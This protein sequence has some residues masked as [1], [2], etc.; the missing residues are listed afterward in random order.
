MHSDWSY[1]FQ[2]RMIT[3]MT[4]TMTM[5]IIMIM[6]MHAFIYECMYVFVCTSS[7]SCMCMYD[8][9]IIIIIITYVCMSECMYVFVC[10]SSHHHDLLFLSVVQ[11]YTIIIIIF[12][13]FCLFFDFLL[14]VLDTCKK[15]YFAH[16]PVFSIY[17]LFSF[18]YTIL[19]I[20]D[21]SELASADKTGALDETHEPFIRSLPED[22]RF[23]VYNY[24]FVTED[25]V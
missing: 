4:T 17:V 10:T 16:F 13:F 22:C 8:T 20:D 21:S 18:R 23:A 3:T 14:P 1:C 24:E 11:S 19:K 12:F 5:V 9:I 25:N 7:S 15:L 6:I 2:D